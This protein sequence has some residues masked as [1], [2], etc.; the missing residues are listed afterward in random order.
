MSN[1]M[2]DIPDILQRIVQRQ[3]EEVAKRTAKMPLSQLQAALAYVAPPRGFAHALTSRIA[4]GQAGVI[5]E[6]KRA[7]PSKGILRMEFHPADIAQSYELGG[8]ACLSVLTEQYFFQGSDAHLQQAR[9]ACTLPI[10]RK[11]FVIDPYQVYEARAIG[12]DAILLIAACLD[13]AILSGLNDLAHQLGMDVLIE[14][15]DATELARAVRLGNRLIGINNRD[16]RTFEINLETTLELLPQL[17]VECLP[18]TESGI[19]SR[20]GVARMRQHGVHG[21]LVGEAFMRAENP[22]ARL[23][24]LFADGSHATQV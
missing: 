21:F 2:G 15:H 19:H 4:A 7:S 11:D 1:F 18:I 10:L 14:I 8:A 9:A 22:G 5:A 17:P 3:R 24:E 16:L 6:I 23:A 12:A 13:D 20:A